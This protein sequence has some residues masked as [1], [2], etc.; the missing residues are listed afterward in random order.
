M[1]ADLDESAASSSLFHSPSLGADPRWQLVQRIVNSPGFT[2]SALLSRFLLYVCSRTLSGRTDEI[3]EVQI[4]V[5]VFGRR[6][7]YSR[8][9]DNI[10]RNY[11]RQLRQRID[12][13]F[14]EDGRLETLRITIPRGQYVPEF[15]SWKPDDLSERHGEPGLALRVAPGPAATE[16]PAPAGPVSKPV[17]SPRTVKSLVWPGVL[18]LLVCGF[19]VQ[20]FLTRAL[21]LHADPAFPLWTQL[22]DNRRL[23]LLVPADDGI[24]MF[25][26]LTQHSVSLAEYISRDY[27]G[28][29]SPFH[30]DARNMA[31]LEAQ[32]Y[33]NIAD[34]YTVMKMARL[35][36]VSADHTA[37]RYAR[38]LHMEDLKDTN[39]V[40]LGSVYSNPWVELF[41]KNLNFT[42]SYQP[43]PNES[44]IIN[45]HPAPGESSEYLNDAAGQTHRTYGVIALVP[46]LNNTG[47]VLIVEGL[48][49]AGTQAA[50][51]MLFSAAPLQPIL[52]KAKSPG[53]GLNP[54]EVL[55]ETSSFGSNAPQARIIAQRIYPRFPM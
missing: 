41:Q 45:R 7:G 35:P 48:T 38:E 33:T 53:G 29:Q 5:H 10:V 28:V 18:L 47:W 31:D 52:D 17:F 50:S 30:I 39:A 40:L 3:S 21:R 6:P 23:T 49:M 54:F 32:R 24:V 13:Y 34:L 9:E 4:G 37:V 11:A 26:N 55:I 46:N 43:R 44:A 25:Q 2:K 14:S 12:H 42:F 22:F 36:E 27:L 15:V 20:L 19:V 16:L 8:G 1:H 51:D